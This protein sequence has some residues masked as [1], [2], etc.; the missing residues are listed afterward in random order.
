MRHILLLLSLTCLSANAAFAQ[1]TDYARPIG[2]ARAYL[3][4]QDL[5]AQPATVDF[6]LFDDDAFNTDTIGGIIDLDPYRSIGMGLGLSAILGQEWM[7]HF[8]FHAGI[9]NG[10]RHFSTL[11]QVSIGRDFWLKYAYAQPMLGIGFSS[12]SYK[13]GEYFPFYKDYI[14]LDGTV[15]INGLTTRLKGRSLML[16]PG[17]LI[18]YP[19]TG[20]LS[21]SLRASINYSISEWHLMSASGATDNVNSE[22]DYVVEYERLRFD[23]NRLDLLINNRRI[24]RRDSPYLHYNFNGFLLQLG[25]SYTIYSPKYYTY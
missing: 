11:S 10:G 15:F 9:G 19:I 14:L 24:L 21:V 7:L 4:W 2:F 12:T 25:I 3:S 18:D 16:T 13:L 1:D 23:D 17:L 22:G 20:S 8:D 6:L 5:N